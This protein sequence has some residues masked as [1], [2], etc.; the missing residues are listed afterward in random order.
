LGST[1]KPEPVEARSWAEVEEVARKMKRKRRK[2]HA[3]AEKPQRGRGP[4]KDLS[5]PRQDSDHRNERLFFMDSLLLSCAVFEA[6]AP[7]RLRPLSLA[8][9]ASS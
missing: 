4:R 9:P 6:M 2:T 8:G 5:L 1:R 3:E 7:G